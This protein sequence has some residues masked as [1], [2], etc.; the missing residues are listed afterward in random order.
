MA[1]AQVH[2]GMCGEPCG[3]YLAE[4]KLAHAVGGCASRGHGAAHA[5]LLLRLV[6]RRFV[7]IA[8]TSLLQ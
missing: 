6:G 8:R 2:K 3:G 7:E 5:L 4:V 1:V